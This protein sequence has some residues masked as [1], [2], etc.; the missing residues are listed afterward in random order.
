MPE[1]RLF[2]LANSI[3]KQ[4]RCVAGREIITPPDGQDYWGGWIRPVSNHDE[5]AI[6]L[7]ECRLDDHCIPEPLDVVSV[8]CDQCENCQT[9]PE[10]WQI[11]PEG[12][13]S[14]IGR[15]GIQNAQQLIESPLNLWSQ[16]GQPTDRVSPSFLNSIPNHQSLYL[17]HPEGF[18]FVIEINPRTDR[19]RARGHFH[20]HGQF[21]NF[22]VTDP[23]ASRKYFPFINNVP[24][25]PIELENPGGSFI[26]VSL[27]PEFMGYHYKIIVTVFEPN[28]NQLNAI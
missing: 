24:E 3:K 11:K 5:G 16:L 19:K 22:S 4:N 14:K 26:C 7:S 10:N 2:V 15:W 20:Y 27:T 1:K 9:Q 6:G 28:Q 17:I 25:G 18:R 23:A 21:Y 12:Q 13:W 8:P